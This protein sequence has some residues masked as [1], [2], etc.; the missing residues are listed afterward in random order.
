MEFT[1]TAA[2]GK[3]TMGW[4]YVFKLHI[5]TNYL[6]EIVA[7]KLTPVNT[8][9]ISTPERLES[10]RSLTIAS[11]YSARRESLDAKLCISPVSSQYRE[12]DG[13]MV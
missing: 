10:E 13:L 11:R 12:P 3:G 8:D 1:G 4:F 6:G 9:D 2:R 7:T 5:I